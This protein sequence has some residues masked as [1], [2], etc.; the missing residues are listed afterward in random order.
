MISIPPLAHVH[1]VDQLRISAR[2]RKFLLRSNVQTVDQ[3]CELSYLDLVLWT[4]PAGSM[5]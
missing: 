2:T 1:L 4:A 3:L 5:S